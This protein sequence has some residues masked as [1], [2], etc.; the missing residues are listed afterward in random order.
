MVN[1]GVRFFQGVQASPVLK[2]VVKQTAEVLKD[3]QRP[4]FFGPRMEFAYA[5]FGE[6]SPKDLGLF[7]GPPTSFPCSEEPRM[8]EV[9]RK[10]RFRTVILLNQDMTYYSV[11]FQ[12]LIFATYEA[13]YVGSI[14]V[15]RLREP[16]IVRRLVYHGEVALS[17]PFAASSC[18]E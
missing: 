16:G 12:K 5:A 11:R 4:V 14:T 8:E 9:W 13:D 1:P 6:P 18:K 7:W 15:L 17:P 2:S 3:A 10:K